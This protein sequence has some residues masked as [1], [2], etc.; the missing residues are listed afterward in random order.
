MTASTTY[1]LAIISSLL[2]RTIV[3]GIERARSPEANADN[4]IL[5]Y[6]YYYYQNIILYNN[7]YIIQS[8]LKIYVI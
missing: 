7:I 8:I 2:L 5:L 3:E 6:Y 1:L 4:I